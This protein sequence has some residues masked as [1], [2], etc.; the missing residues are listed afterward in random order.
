VN[1]IVRWFVRN[2]VAANLLMGL[3]IVLGVTSLFTIK[4]EVF[5][6]FSTDMISVSVRY[7]GAAPAEV[8]EGV[9]VRIEERLQGLDGVKKV[10]STANENVGAVLVE[11]DD[12]YDAAR[13]L[14]DIKSRVDAIDTFP[15]EAEEPVIEELVMTRQ[16]IEV[17]LYGDAE[18]RTLK[19]LG[20]RLREDL[21]A[22]PDISQVVLVSTRPYEISIEVSEEALRGYGLTFDEVANAVRRSSVDLPGGRI[23][24]RAGEILL[25]GEGQ[26]Y[27]GREFE[28]IPLRALA[29]GTRLT[30]GDVAVVDDGFADADLWSRFN[31]KPAVI[32]QVFR[33]G[34][35]S[36]TD[37]V[38]A[39]KTYLE[40][41]E[42]SLPSGIE[43]A[44]YQDETAILRARLELLT[45]NGIA[46][47]LLVF[48]VLALF[49]RLSLAA[50]VA[51]GI[52]ISFLGG[53]AVMPT[54]DVSINMISLFAFIIVLGIVVDDAIVVGENIY[55]HFQRG[56]SAVDAAIAGTSEVLKPVIF[57]VLTTI[58]A[59]APILG[60]SGI[61]GKFMRVIPIIVI[62][63]LVFSLAESLLILPAHL[64]HARRRDPAAH[65]PFWRR[66]QKRVSEG[67]VTFIERRYQ[68]FLDRVI[69]WRYAT[70]AVGIC[71]LLITGA[72]VAAGW[73]EFNFMPPIES[74]NV[75]VSLTMPQG[76]PAEVTDQAIRRIESAARELQ[77]EVEDEYG[78]VFRHTLASVG[79]QP[80]KQSE[81]QRFGDATKDF[82]APHLGEVNIELVGAEERDITSIEIADRW[83]EKVG[84]IPDAVE[85]SFTS[86]LFSSGNP[87]HVQLSGPNVDRLHAAAEQLKEALRSYPGVREIADSFRAG[88][89]ELDLRVTPEGE[90][91]GLSQMALARQVRQAFYGEEAQR[92]L[93]GRDEVKVMVRYP[94]AD[95]L[96]LADLEGLRLR[97]QDGLEIPL[98]TAAVTSMS[99]G[100]ATIERTD[101]R[102]VVNVTADVDTA[103][104]NANAILADLEQS[105]L[106]SLLAD[107]P[108]V[109]Y[110]FEGEQEQQRETLAGLTRGFIIALFVIYGLLA[111]PFRSYVQPLIVMSA[112]PFGIIGAVWGHLIMGKSLAIMSIFGIVALTGV[113]INDS[114]VLVDFVN[115]EVDEGMSHREAIRRGGAGRFR[116]ILLTSLTTFAG[117][118]PLLLERSL[119]AQFLIPMAIS[120]AFGVLFATFITLLLVPALYAIVED[121]REKLAPSVTATTTDDQTPGLLP[122]EA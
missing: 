79:S 9:V 122:E 52:P 90:A 28:R 100:P 76:T 43:V 24:S 22:L 121:V 64:S 105:F 91:A 45:R 110:S 26:A 63:T 103:L 114:L 73:L 38:A 5:P 62:A 11:I 33:T 27:R 50:W 39:T 4:K 86:S 88:K 46:G 66:V 97:G 49:L 89:R 18:E 107:F 53:F 54:L 119:Q 116:P 98:A 8:E 117:L 6:E 113:V 71:L 57:A 13:L 51:L 25:R 30:V 120:L 12:G 101:R 65:A 15:E 112:I 109:R 92:V 44:T 59:F 21:A 69:A 77:R 42:S 94:K 40:S 10:R 111:I 55:S 87:I 67:L 32:L 83:R 72:V 82:S 58:A 20:D 74:D 19:V 56:L 99:R 34:E 60:V 14:N 17:A 93:R 31:G 85:M 70:V 3:L 23:D 35:Q 108:D 84:A 41:I 81:N 102:R 29:D 106:P 115:R 68:P 37:V 1:G 104:G 16:V 95:R 2:G 48:F 80:F 96:S 47:F 7:P 61:I 36:A 118:T 75:A 78:E